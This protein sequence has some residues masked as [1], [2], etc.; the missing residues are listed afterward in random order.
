[1]RSDPQ[2]ISIY[3]NYNYYNI[4]TTLQ[5]RDNFHNNSMVCI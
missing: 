5:F 2:D 3:T 1:M 4:I